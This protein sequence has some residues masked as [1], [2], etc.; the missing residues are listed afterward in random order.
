MIEIAMFDEILCGKRAQ[1]EIL[2]C[3]QNIRFRSVKVRRSLN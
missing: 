2:L 1:N 3:F